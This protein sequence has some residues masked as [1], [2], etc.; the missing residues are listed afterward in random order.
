MGDIGIPA[1]PGAEDPTGGVTTTPEGVTTAPDPTPAQGTA[2]PGRDNF[3]ANVAP[4]TPS[5]RVRAVNNALRR[6]A[7]CVIYI[8]GIN[9]TDKLLP[10]LISLRVV[11][12]IEGHNQCYI[13]L[14]DREA[15]LPM[16]RANEVIRIYLGWAGEGPKIPLFRRAEYNKDLLPQHADIG[17][18]RVDD[19]AELP[20][21][22]GGAMLMFNGIV[23][24]VESAFSRKGGGRQ[25]ILQGGPPRP[26]G[27]SDGGKASSG[28]GFSKG[29][30]MT[31]MMSGALGGS[32]ASS[33]VSPSMQGL[34]RSFWFRDG[35]LLS[36]AAQTAAESGG[37]F[38]SGGNNLVLN[39][40]LDSQNVKGNGM[41]GVEASWGVNLISWRVIP[42]ILRAQA[43]KAN[44]DYFDNANG[45]FK[46]VSQAISGGAPHNA[47][48]VIQS[49][50]GMAPNRRAAQQK[51]Q[52]MVANSTT[53]RG[54]GWAII[55]GE[56]MARAGGYL[57][58]DGARPGV[59]GSWRIKEVEHTYQRQGGYTTRCMLDNPNLGREYYGVKGSGWD[60]PV[61]QA[62]ET[63]G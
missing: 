23:E 63:A 29:I 17:K 48:D 57:I 56:P 14:D 32:G 40:A 61:Q 51:T 54:N 39:N 45:V 35:S 5:V 12:R 60:K 3:P 28:N 13:T 34:A 42:Y 46:R 33:G 9:V 18:A 43:A 21:A 20:Y 62:W 6:H 31:D 47:S 27:S 24:L 59:D 25:L 55:N 49:I 30:S 11:E 53:E 1:D 36:H 4:V 26:R 15:K 58:I 19:P 52:G 22:T 44:A 10:F 8:Q 50:V 41:P 38:S 7:H 37:V 2:G 16:F